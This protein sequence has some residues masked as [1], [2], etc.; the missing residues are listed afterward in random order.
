ME[1]I[2][3]YEKLGEEDIKKISDYYHRWGIL[4]INQ[5]SDE[6]NDYIA[7]PVDESMYIPVKDFLEKWSICKNTLY[8]LLGNQMIY[9]VPFTYQKLEDDIWNECKDY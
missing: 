4:G 6:I 8:K 3:L 7:A 9:K 1:R 5:W 2:D